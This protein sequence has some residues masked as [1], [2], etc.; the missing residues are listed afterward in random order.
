MGAPT[1][2][3]TISQQ[4]HRSCRAEP[5]PDAVSRL[6]YGALLLIAFV[7]DLFFPAGWHRSGSAISQPLSRSRS[8]QSAEQVIAGGGGWPVTPSQLTVTLSWI[9]GCALLTS[10]GFRW[11]PG[12]SL[13]RRP[14]QMR[15]TVLQRLS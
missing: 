15:S 12:R 5:R 6:A 4:H 3:T 7:P 11:Q 14:R 1:T 10:V 13:L 2:D 9:A 8:S